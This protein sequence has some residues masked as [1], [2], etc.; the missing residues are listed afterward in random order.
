MIPVW[1]TVYTSTLERTVARDFV[2]PSCGHTDT[3]LVTARGRG[4]GEAVYGIGE[5]S[6][7]EA[8]QS[9][10]ERAFGK[11][12]TFLASMAR[13]PSCGASPGRTAEGKR[14]AA[15]VGGALAVGLVCGACLPFVPLRVVWMFSIGM[16]MGVVMAIYFAIERAR[17]WWRGTRAERALFESKLPTDVVRACAREALTRG[18]D[19]ERLAERA[20]VPLPVLAFYAIEES[21]AQTRSREEELRRENEALR[22]ENERLRQG[23]F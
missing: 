21:N 17:G 18:A 13:C 23:A 9:R 6:A 12:A 8:A 19:L 22:R 1:Q 14:A 3:L 16:V 4:Q 15:W 5:A 20:G 7:A 10:A 2:C 11:E